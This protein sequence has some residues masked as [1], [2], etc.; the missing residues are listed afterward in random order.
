MSLQIAFVFASLVV[1]AFGDRAP[2]YGAPPTYA[3]PAYAPPAPKYVAPVSY[4]EPVY[5]DEP[6]KYTFN[7]GVADSLGAN[8]PLG[9]HD[10]YNTGVA[11][12][13][14][15]DGR[16]QTVTYYDNGDGLVAEVTYQGEAQYPEYAPAYK[17]AP[18]YKPAPVP[19]Y[20]PAPAYSAPIIPAYA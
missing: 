13:N 5:P 15:P 17:P 3:P 16:I 14:L 2:V 18:S 1:L 12:V 11:T 4:N 8:W 10:G 6:P 7:Y 20:E 9:I 19:A